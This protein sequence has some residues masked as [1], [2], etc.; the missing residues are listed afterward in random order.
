MSA[1]THAA[2]QRAAQEAQWADGYALFV[3]GNPSAGVDGVYARA[4]EV[5]G[6]PYGRKAGSA[7]D[8]VLFLK[9]SA[10]EWRVGIDV[11]N[12]D[13]D[14]CMASVRCDKDTACLPEG[15]HEWHW[16]DGKGFKTATV[17]VARAPHADAHRQA[18]VCDSQFPL[19]CAV[20]V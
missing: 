12:A 2:T 3:S 1:Q 10:G 17:N 4:G 16:S 19:V 14:V 13:S 11:S 9:P 7:A 6:A 18:D 15:A 8:R 20:C 5:N